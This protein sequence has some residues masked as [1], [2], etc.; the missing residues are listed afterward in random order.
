MATIYPLVATDYVEAKI[1]VQ[2]ASKN[3]IF[4]AQAS[5]EF[6]MVLIAV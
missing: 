5:P 2:A 3:A 4:D 6:M 1:R